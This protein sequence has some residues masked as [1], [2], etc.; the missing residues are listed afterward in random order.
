M[1][2][3]RI[4]LTTQQVFLDDH[5]VGNWDMQ[6]HH[7]AHIHGYPNWVEVGG[8]TF[9]KFQLHPVRNWKRPRYLT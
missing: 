3:D 6:V 2:I 7:R 8:I 4:L 1:D 5:S 9:V